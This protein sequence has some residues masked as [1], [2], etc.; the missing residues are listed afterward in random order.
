[1]ENNTIHKIAGK[2][3][4]LQSKVPQNVKLAVGQAM[5]I[6]SS[7]MAYKASTIWDTS[8]AAGTNLW[9][10]LKDLYCNAIFLPLLIAT[11]IGWA[12]LAKNEKAAGAFKTAIKAECIAFIVLQ[13]PT[14][15][16]ATLEQIGGWLNGSST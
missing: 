11:I 1:M 6:Y 4:E 8:E 9:G 14:V 13:F 5:I 2:A 10:K 3:Y 16:T 12:V 15:I 7:L